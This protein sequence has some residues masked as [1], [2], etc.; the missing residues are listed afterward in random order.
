[1]LEPQAAASAM[2]PYVPSQMP[3]RVTA[4]EALPEYRLKVR[5]CDGT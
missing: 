3:L 2:A 4:V 5:F 1:M